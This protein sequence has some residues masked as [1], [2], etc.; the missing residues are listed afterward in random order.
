MPLAESLPIA[1]IRIDSPLPHLDRIF[2]YGVPATMAAQAQVGVRVRV[3]FSG[4]LVNGFIVGRSESSEIEGTLRPLDRVISPEIVLTPEVMQLVEAVAARYA[5]T[6][7]DVV[8]MAVPARHARAE[9]VAVSAGA[10]DPLAGDD[11]VGSWSSYVHGPALVERLRTGTATGLRGVWAAAP[12]RHWVHDVASAVRSVLSRPTGGAIIVVPDGWDVDQ[13]T[14]ALADCRPA[15]AL[16]SADLGPERRYREFCRVLRGAARVVVGTRTAVFAPVRDLELVVVWDD[17]NDLL[18]EP[19]APYWNVRDVA[20]LRSHLSGCAL[21]VGS[22]SRSVETQQ[23]CATGWAQSLTPTREAIR[24]RAPIVRAFEAGDEARDEAAASARIPRIAWLVAKEGVRSGP[25]LIQVARK[26][27]LPVLSCVQC[28]EPARCACGGPLG[29]APR[30]SAARCEW[31]GKPAA[32]WSCA[33]CGATRFRAGA[34]GVER[35]AEEFGRAFPGE[36]IIWSGGDQIVRVV[37]DEPAIVIATHGAEPVAEG[38]YS[39][40]IVLDARAQ[41]QRPNLRAVE[42]AAHRWFSALM[43]ARPKAHAVVTVENAALPVQALA[44]WDAPWLAER[45]LADRT[46]AGLPPATR[47]IVLRGA[48]SDIE[49]VS[50]SLTAPH[51]LLG[52][53]DGRAIVLT[54]RE[55]ASELA[56]E[57]RAITA[58]RAAK[59]A[60]GQVTVMVDPRTFDA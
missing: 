51:R 54:S 22:P 35:T 46:S 19:H 18:W 15:I 5:G 13:L 37:A 20:A 9:S 53:V 57:L 44:R 21:L 50:G 49:T 30:A 14:S 11:L 3:R 33:V 40:V 16:L 23:W 43:L 55:A 58:T 52:P 2:D 48:A 8:R 34:V 60:L 41:L 6:F 26:G 31:C 29:L 36:R 28:R 59:A 10:F 1:Q 56:R 7:S 27:Y 38:G 25:V 45:E 24:D 4:R 47:A 42:D 17:G 39:A 32:D 12:A